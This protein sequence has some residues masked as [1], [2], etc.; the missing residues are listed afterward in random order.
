MKTEGNESK[1]FIQRVLISLIDW[2]EPDPTKADELVAAMRRKTDAA[3]KAP[4]EKVEA[5]MQALA[6]LQ[7]CLISAA[8]QL[9]GPAGDHAIHYLPVFMDQAPYSSDRL[10]SGVFKDEVSG[11]FLIGIGS[12][13]RT[14][15]D[16]I[17]EIAH[18]CLHLLDPI[19]D[20]RS[21][22]VATIEEG[23]AVK[24]AE[25]ILVAHMLPQGSVRPLGS[26][27]VSLDSHYAAAYR[28]ARKIPDAE[29]RKTRAHFGKFSAVS[30][31]DEYRALV[32]AYIDDGQARM[33]A[34]PF[35]YL[36]VKH[37]G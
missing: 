37:A 9:Y 6:F 13:A 16:V 20:V 28:A 31:T 21:T 12:G 24:Y 22:P 8:E 33:L 26:L 18:E 36:A 35:V 29:L 32:D 23:V 17:Y 15:A 3:T 2:L 4:R 7:S 25:D 14:W 11:K 27:S 30:D 34:K 5:N 10:N 1:E 19:A